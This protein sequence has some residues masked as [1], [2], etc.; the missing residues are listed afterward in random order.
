MVVLHDETPQRITGDTQPA[1]RQGAR[2]L[3]RQRFSGAPRE[4]LLLFDEALALLADRVPLDIEIKPVDDVAAEDVATRVLAALVRAGS[5]Q[6]IVVTSSDPEILRAL[7]ARAPRL[8]LGFVAFG[9][10]PRPAIRTAVDAVCELLVIS[11]RRVDAQT[12]SQAHAN[13]L[14]VWTYT[15][16]SA[17]EADAL[18]AQGVD[19]VISDDYPRLERAID[20]KQAVTETERP[21]LL[22]LDLG[23]TST[24]AALVCPQRG[25]VE[26]ATVPT[27]AQA[28]DGNVEHDPR[29]CLSAARDVLTALAAR[30]TQVPAALGIAAQRSTGLWLDRNDQPLTKAPSWRDP[31][32]GDLIERLGTRR[33]AMERIA[34]FPLAAAWTAVKA[35]ALRPKPEESDKLAPLGAWIA[36]QLCETALVVDPTLANR[37]Y[38]LDDA[39]LRWSSFLAESFALS[40]VH[41]PAIVPTV[42]PHGAFPWPTGDAVAWTTLIGDQQAAYVGAAGPLEKRLVLNLGTAVFAMRVETMR[43]PG[44]DDAR[45][46]PLWTSVAAA[47]PKAR[48]VELPLVELPFDIGIGVDGGA[49]GF[50]REVARRLA[51]GDESP[52]QFANAIAQAVSRL[53]LPLDQSVTICGGGATSPHFVELLSQVLPLTPMVCNEPEAT[54]LG[55]ARLAAA[56]AKITWGL[57]PGAGAQP[58]LRV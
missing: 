3:I 51:F 47:A 29:A 55:A 46:A 15:I 12:V 17:G 20:T 11:R 50:A 49:D 54:L 30:T 42:G 2:D 14:T 8:A 13:G 36:A 58:R 32:G 52:V 9:D 6:R 21:L 5:P 44:L 26:R 37:M 7:K 43:R 4:T 53:Q 33:D 28:L 25:I 35:N 34:G 1:H 16:D 40:P 18:F 56:G 24:K 39:T 10:D 22:A 31:R 57:A 27:P 23:S 48:L 38:L 45:R 41:L 19:A